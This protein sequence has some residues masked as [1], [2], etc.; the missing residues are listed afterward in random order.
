M[1]KTLLF[2]KHK[3]KGQMQI[4]DLII[5][6]AIFLILF[7]FL[8]FQLNK[9][10]EKKERELVVLK[11]N[12]IASSLL[13]DLVY[14]YGIPTNWAAASLEPNNSLFKAIGCAQSFGEI[15]EYKL[16]RLNQIFNNSY[17]KKKLQLGEFDADIFVSYLNNTPVIYI[18]NFSSKSE[19]LAVK[20]TFALYNNSIVQVRVRVWD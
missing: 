12:N 19:P 17:T 10:L 2:P 4:A 15:D 9:N 3:K 7:S 20:K 6:L 18:G 11:A 1:V 8:Y 5:S 14:S 16:Y 13:D